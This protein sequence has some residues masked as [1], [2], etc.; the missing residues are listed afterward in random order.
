MNY[1]NSKSDINSDFIMQSFLD[2]SGELSVSLPDSITNQRLLSFFKKLLYVQAIDNLAIQLQRTGI[3]GTY[4]A[5][6]GSEAFSVALG[7]YLQPDDIFVPYYRDQGTLLARGYT[8]G[9][10]IGYWGGDARSGV[11]Y[12][13]DM[14]ICIPIATQC[15]HAAGIAYA[16]KISGSSNIV[17][18]NIGDGGTS[19]GDFYES[20]NFAS[21][22]NLPIIYF[23]INNQWAIS[24]PL[25]LQT[26]AKTIAHKSMAVGCEAMRIDGADPIAVLDQLKLAFKFCRN[27]RKPLLVEILTYR[28]CDHTTADDSSRYMPKEDLENAIQA[29][30]PNR[31]KRYLFNIGL[32]NEAQLLEMKSTIKEEVE[33]D[34]DRIL[35]RNTDKPESMFDYLY[36]ELPSELQAQRQDLKGKFNA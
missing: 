35:N 11:G 21:V 14:P 10:I 19:K 8:A 36:Y 30:A 25:H 22:H 3:I 12:K 1:H 18:C 32:L 5:A 33:M 17:C 6:S 9:D 34:A 23:V 15:S 24:V 7:E 26:A 29:S 4:P 20:L 2:A 16:E 27:Q 13:K 28:M 31:L